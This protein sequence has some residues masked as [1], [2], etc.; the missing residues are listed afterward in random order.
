MKAVKAAYII[1][2]SVFVL[3]FA[4]SFFLGRTIDGYKNE[5]DAIDTS[6]TQ[7]AKDKVTEIYEKFKR[8]E[9]FINLT[10]THEDLTNIEE[11]F[12]GMIGAAKG[13]DKEEL[14]IEKS[15]LSDAL[16]HLKRLVGINLD[17][18]L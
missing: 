4:N 17:S 15:R 14:E 2:V 10:V 1:F 3:V 18:I 16:G 12:S 7:A 13:D 11:M 5:I 8:D 6:N 9:K